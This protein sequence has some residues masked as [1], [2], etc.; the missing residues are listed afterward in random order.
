MIEL[1]VN[2]PAFNAEKYIAQAIQSV[3][4]TE[5]NMEVLVLDDGSTDSIQQIIA[6]A[7]RNDPRVKLLISTKNSG[8]AAARQKLIDHSQGEFIIPFDSDDIMLPGWIDYAVD[9]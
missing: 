3:L 4:Q 7:S 2:I 6:D 1:S 8:I 5:K 9:I